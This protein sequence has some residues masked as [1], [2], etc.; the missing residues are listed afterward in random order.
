MNITVHNT[1][2][3]AGNGNMSVHC[4]IEY[5]FYTLLLWL[6]LFDLTILCVRVVCT[7]SCTNNTNSRQGNC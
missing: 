4:G 6:L 1:F 3:W 5:H 2:P 7:D